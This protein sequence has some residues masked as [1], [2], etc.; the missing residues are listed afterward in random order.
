METPPPSQQH[1]DRESHKMNTHSTSSPSGTHSHTCH[2]RLMGKYIPHRRHDNRI[3]SHS[4][5]PLHILFVCMYE[6]VCEREHQHAHLLVCW[7]VVCTVCAL[8]DSAAS[9]KFPYDEPRGRLDKAQSRN[10]D[11]K[12]HRS[13][14]GHHNVEC[15][16]CIPVMERH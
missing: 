5:D 15:E 9:H 14:P 8:R 12:T 10:R 4:S 11:R 7:R 2:S 6:L 1:T 13:P 3:I 16:A